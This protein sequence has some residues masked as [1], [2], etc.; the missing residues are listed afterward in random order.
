M[1]R[2]FTLPE[3]MLVLAVAG[4]LLGIA[5][6]SLTDAWNRI[7]VESAA[8]QLVTA[9]QRGRMMAIAL[10]RVLTLSIDSSQL[11]ISPRDSG[12]PLWSSPGPAVL[13]VALSGPVRQ[14]IFSPE[15][16]TLGFSNA[17]MRLTRGASSRTIVISRLGRVRVVR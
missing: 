14:F 11:V 10:S 6:P 17:T 7:Q 1:R 13:G 12:G 16:F 9:H 4:I 3:L 8:N 2:A 15:G 5:V